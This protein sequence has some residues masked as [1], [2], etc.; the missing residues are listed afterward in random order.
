M[1]T[2][3][4]KFAS[5]GASPNPV[6][7][8]IVPRPNLGSVIVTIAEALLAIASAPLIAFS[9]F[10]VFCRSDGLYELLPLRDLTEASAHY[11]A[12]QTISLPQGAS[13]A[14]GRV[15]GR[16]PHLLVVAPSAEGLKA[17]CGLA[18][19]CPLGMFPEFT[20]FCCRVSSGRGQCSR[21]CM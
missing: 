4:N 16:Q 15:I 14:R 8:P 18:Q 10:E 17:L 6:R 20:R 3:Q 2:I 7:H 9:K 11:C 1:S 19:D 5:A 12:V 13:G 21:A